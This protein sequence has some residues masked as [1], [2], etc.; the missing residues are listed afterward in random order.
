VLDLM[1]PGMD[2]MEVRRHLKSNPRTAVIPVIAMSAGSNLLAH[3][4]EM[5]AD[6]YLAKPFDLAE[7]TLRIQRWVRCAPAESPS[8]R[9]P[10][11]ATAELILAP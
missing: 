10:R 5:D 2:G 3:A 4:K 1:M 9:E 7:L 11:A 6:D 8:L